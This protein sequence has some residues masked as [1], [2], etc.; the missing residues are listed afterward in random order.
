MNTKRTIRQQLMLGT[1]IGGSVLAI[2]GAA[3]AQD[4]PVATADQDDA[5]DIGEVV[6]TGSRIRR[7]PT[8]APTPLIQ[9]QRE[10]LDRTGQASLIEYLATIPALSN[11]Q[12]PADTTA[13]VLNAGGLS[14]PNL[15]SLGS[16]RTLTLVDGRRHV[17][18]QGGTLAVDTD[19]I[20][21][22]LIDSIEIVT[23]GASSVYGAD[24]VSGVLNFILKKDF[25]GLEID[26]R[27]A[28]V[29]QDGQMQ[30]R[31]AA[32]A[33]AN[34]FD[35]R[36]NV[37]AFGE[38]EKG[39]G[40]DATDLD[41]LREGNG[42]VGNDADTGALPSDGVFDSLLWSNRRTLQINRWGVVTVANQ[43]RPSPLSDPD[44]LPTN[45]DATGPC[46]GVATVASPSPHLN[47]QCF[48]VAPGSTWVFDGPTARLAD[49][50]S[51][52]QG[53]GLNRT[54]NV[55][56][57]GENPN[58]IFNVD[59]TYPETESK[60]FQAGLNFALTP[61]INL[62]AEAKY[63]DEETNLATGFSFGTIYIGDSYADTDSQPILGGS[64][65]WAT[66]LDNAY[67]PSNLRDAIRNNRITNYCTNTAGCAGG[68]AYGAVLAT[69]V[70]APFAKYD[71]WLLE[72][73]Q[74]NYRTLQRYVV[75]ADGELGDIGFIRNVNWDIGYTHGRMDNLNFERGFDGERM[76][77][78][79]DAVVDTAGAV[80]GRPG[81]IVCRVQLLTAGGGTVANRNR[82]VAGNG[83]TSTAVTGVGVGPARIDR[84]DADISS[85]APL[86]MFGKG[87]QSAAG[88]AYVSAEIFVDQVNT[89]EDWL[90]SISGQLWDFWG[91]GP[92]GV[93]LGAE[94]RE[95]FTEGTGRSRSTAGRLLQ[96][97]TGSDQAP[98]SYDTTEYF[99]ELSI[100]LIQ[101]SW[102]GEYA[103]LSG[104]YRYADFSTSGEQEV[105]GVNLVYRPIHDVAFKTS[106]NTSIR[107]PSL[108]E[109]FGPLTQTFLLFT[110]PCDALN[111]QN[112][113]DRAQAANR[114][115]NCAALAAREG[116]TFNFADPAAGNAFRPTYVSSVA[117][118]N[119]GNPNLVPEEAESFTFSTVLQP[120]F[121]PD[122]SLVLD[123][124]DIKIDNV[125]AAVSAQV[126][127]NNCVNGP[128]LN[129]AAC[130]TLNRARVDDPA[131]A[132]DDRFALV[133]FIQGSINYAKRTVRGLDFTATY[134]LDS[135]E[136]FG[137]NFGRFAY[138][139]N[140][141]WLIE[142]KNFNNLDN[143]G[144][145]TE[146]ASTLNATV[147]PRV[148]MTSSLS[149]TPV[150]R[151]TFTWDADFQT[152][153]DI[154]QRRSFITN[155]DQR[156][157]GMLDTGNFV[158]H[159][160]SARFDVRDDLT[161]RAGVVNAF[162]QEQ[163][164]WLGGT[165]L[166]SLDPFGRRFSVG[167]TWRPY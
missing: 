112:W 137:R 87:N 103:E 115:V 144:D 73:T 32:L 105:Y 6:V 163:A 154:V 56:G 166:T 133:G 158:R 68:I 77:Y 58:T 27:A 102:L 51:W 5:T 99:A 106:F 114:L 41:W 111:I 52:V 147:Y 48:G 24:A 16:G 34:L 60:R 93:A 128:T 17:G 161:L 15:R 140:G 40:V 42:L 80:N 167:L 108:S 97:N 118:Q 162:D 120:S 104:S 81:E 148:R 86:N 90:G 78:A 149:W 143:P 28:Q 124:Y 30:Y 46:T 9:I 50:G 146:L 8:T 125:I 62:R 47:S 63:V 1:I 159:D 110:D 153:V 135:E 134:R 151:V 164:P 23:G 122:F 142:Q 45:T 88:L 65:T 35:D 136:A 72:R 61:S 129:E 139:L 79:L 121:I 21:R 22:L 109:S 83:S 38:Y 7:D 85:C 84:T 117:G 2:A 82:F 31:F 43:Y 18:S 145:F 126:A 155:P 39:E 157:P 75:S 130:A 36:L 3:L 127:A 70:A 55:G 89:Q 44:S 71:G 20:P 98:V 57:D 25:E 26:T 19:T 131:T 37:Y 165:I 141:S 113:A 66:R 13:G 138:R 69:N 116:L 29:N 91:A 150:E 132:R 33:G 12:V 96:L 14:L 94:Y 160:F 74:T 53:T 59:A 11:S 107:A 67:L 64:N 92:I 119:G 4:A 49:F 123:Y 76:S 100:P 152:A 10:T 156:D 95:E 101:D 54:N